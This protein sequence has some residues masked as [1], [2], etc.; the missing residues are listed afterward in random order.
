MPAPKI[1]YQ[2][3]DDATQLA[4]Y[5]DRYPLSFKRTPLAPLIP[6]PLTLSER[7]G[8]AAADL[9]PTGP[10][11]LSRSAADA[12]KA[13]GQL[14][15]VS[16]RIT[17]EDGLPLAGAVVEIWQANSAGKYIHD[18]DR[19]NAPIDPNFTGEGRLVTDA[20]GQFQFFSIK[21]G[22]YPVL[23]SGWWWRPP[24]IHFS[25][26]GRS[27]MDR[28]VTQ[29]FFPGEPLNETD[30]L[31]NAV[32]ERDVRE[33]LIFEFEGTSMGEVNAMGFRRDFVLRGRRQTPELD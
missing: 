5:I 1:D 10:L 3:Y 24:H 33:R 19:H 23:E 9:F 31:L 4:R 32:S 14:I 16:G 30:L 20:E 12:P 27:W 6:R 18:M 2:P 15:Q 13:T 25:I 22:A 28:F 7:T 8:L 21:P 26:L 29:I 11:D 17:D